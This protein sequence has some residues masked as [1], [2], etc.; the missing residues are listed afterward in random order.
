MIIKI[1]DFKDK[2]HPGLVLSPVKHNMEDIRILKSFIRL[3]D[4]YI[5]CVLDPEKP[6]DTDE[7]Y[8]VGIIHGSP[9]HAING[10]IERGQVLLD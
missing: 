3:E 1:L 7:F 2:I 10:Y 6:S 4:G 5:D 8:V 9:A